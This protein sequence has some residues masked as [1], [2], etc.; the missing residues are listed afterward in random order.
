MWCLVSSSSIFQ[1]LGL[2]TIG[3]TIGAAQL[4]SLYEKAVLQR[5][6][7][8][9]KLKPMGLTDINQTAWEM[10][11]SK[12]YQKYNCVEYPIY[13]YNTDNNQRQV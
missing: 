1:L 7:Q 11:I 10:R 3:A 2:T 6:E 5:L 13:L 9:D 4:D 8:A 12:E